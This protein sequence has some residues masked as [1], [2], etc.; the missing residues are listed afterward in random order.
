MFSPLNE[1]FLF[2]GNDCSLGKITLYCLN[3]NLVLFLHSAV[4]E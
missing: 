2:L 4:A 3:P 1:L